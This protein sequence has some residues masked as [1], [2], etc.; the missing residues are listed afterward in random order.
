MADRD[1]P[2]T[3]LLRRAANGEAEAGDAAL[4][5][6][7]R[8]LRRIARARMANERRDHTLQATALVHETWLRLVGMGGGDWSDRAAFYRAA[9]LAMRR[10][11]VEHA[12]RRSRHKRG[13]DVAREPVSVAG[14]PAPR[15]D[16]GCAATFLQLDEEIARLER[17]DP[18]AGEIVRLRFFAGLGV[19]E[20]AAALGLSRRTVLREWAFARA[21]LFAALGEGTALP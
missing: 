4:P 1:E 13:G 14:L 8:E 3:Q 9:A 15:P 18:R 7:Y 12:R 2:L 20:T 21:Q 19:D 11:L 16:L 17:D 6:V 5:L 10:I